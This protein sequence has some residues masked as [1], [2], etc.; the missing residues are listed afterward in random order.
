M[1]SSSLALRGASGVW[2][3]LEAE[4][5]KAPRSP[6]DAVRPAP[7]GPPPPHD[8]RRIVPAHSQ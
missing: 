8:L 6:P 4:R 5:R 7:A 1:S 3:L 2:C